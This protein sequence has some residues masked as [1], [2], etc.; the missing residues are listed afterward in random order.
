M[1][2]SLNVSD[3]DFVARMKT[4]LS[5]AWWLTLFPSSSVGTKS[6]SF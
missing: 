4:Y 1:A 3:E 2:V 6:Q 5:S